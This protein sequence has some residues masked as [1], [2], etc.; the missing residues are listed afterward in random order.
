[1]LKCGGKE[2]MKNITHKTGI[3]SGIA[4]GFRYEFQVKRHLKKIGSRRFTERSMNVL[5]RNAEIAAPILGN[6]LRNIL[7]NREHHLISYHGSI[8]SIIHAFKSL[9]HVGISVERDFPILLKVLNYISSEHPGISN[10]ENKYLQEL[11]N[12]LASKLASSLARIN[13]ESAIRLLFKNK[14][15]IFRNISWSAIEL[16][17]N[18]MLLLELVDDKDPMVRICVINSLGNINKPNNETIVR[19][20]KALDDENPKVS[21][22]AFDTL[23]YFLTGKDASEFIQ[24][25]S[26]KDSEIRE[27]ALK[28]IRLLLNDMDKWGWEKRERIYETLR[29]I[30]SPI[31]SMFI[32]LLSDGD[33]SIRYNIALALSWIREPVREVVPALIGL[34]ND[35]QR[36]CRIVW[37]TLCD[38]DESVLI[39]LIEFL[40]EE[41]SAVRDEIT[42][43]LADIRKTKENNK[44]AYEHE[45]TPTE[46]S[47]MGYDTGDGSR[48]NWGDYNEGTD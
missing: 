30:G 6:M 31:I 13:S 21:S 34:L 48:D 18:A 5:A 4:S 27:C 46:I 42:N 40:G 16:E 39:E 14:G 41:N 32:Q 45:S 19:L 24:V 9:C 1:M 36:F 3:I 35:D 20:M 7:N 12:E 2:Q 44:K 26:E 47:P 29:K 43:I 10:H 33:Y 28:F 17:K 8:S 22:S 11:Y 15:T 37:K 25:L 23:E 38:I